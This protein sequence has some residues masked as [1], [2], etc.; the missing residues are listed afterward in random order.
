MSKLRIP[1]LD[2]GGT[3]PAEIEYS[4][5]EADFKLFATALAAEG[6]LMIGAHERILRPRTV[7]LWCPRGFFCTIGFGLCAASAL[8][9][10]IMSCAIIL[11]PS[12][13]HKLTRR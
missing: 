12:V 2:E 9:G 5:D 8:P 3:L 13:M 7:G 1:D 10:P 11:R 4:G 6:V